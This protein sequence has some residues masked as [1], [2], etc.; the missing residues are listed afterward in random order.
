MVEPPHFGTWTKTTRCESEIF[1]RATLPQ[2]AGAFG[3]AFSA[4]DRAGSDVAHVVRARARDRDRTPLK[5]APSPVTVASDGSP[6]A[7]AASRPG[8]APSR[9]RRPRWAATPVA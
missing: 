6:G 2:R 7:A 4:P 5:A 3:R 9:R 1:M 8:P